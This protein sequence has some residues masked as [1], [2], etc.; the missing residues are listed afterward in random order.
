MA[1]PRKRVR[2]AV[3]RNRLK[4]LIRESFRKHQVILGDLDIVVMVNT[5]LENMDNRS[6]SAS[7]NKQWDKL[8]ICGK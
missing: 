3:T 8:I 4:R 6:I 1:I 5:D 2:R 7:I